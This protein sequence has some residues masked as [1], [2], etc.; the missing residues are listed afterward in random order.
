VLH[1]TGIYNRI[2]G[3]NKG[4]IKNRFFLGGGQWHLRTKQ[5]RCLTISWPRW[6]SFTNAYT[7]S[8][9]TSIEEAE[10]YTDAWHNRWNFLYI[11]R[12]RSPNQET[13][14]QYPSPPKQCYSRL[15]TERLPTCVIASPATTRALLWRAICESSGDL[16]GSRSWSSKHCSGEESREN[17]GDNLHDGA[18][19]LLM[20]FQSW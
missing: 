9:Y 7:I 3:Y 14:E 20:R 15:A 17:E 1:G 19:N 5:E 4:I 6:T 12:K 8:Q 2:Y 11:R 10:K 13:T 18:I 16:A